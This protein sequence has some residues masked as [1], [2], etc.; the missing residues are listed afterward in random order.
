MYT[1]FLD[2]YIYILL[3]IFLYSLKVNRH[4]IN[5]IA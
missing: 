1:Y 5:I 4:K 2:I 3:N